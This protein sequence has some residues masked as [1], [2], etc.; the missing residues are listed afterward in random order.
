MVPG[1]RVSGRKVVVVGAGVAGL[2]AASVLAKDGADVTVLERRPYVGG[3]AYSYAHP[4]L[5]E[6]VDSQHVLLGCCTNLLAFCE[7]AGLAGKVRWYDR[8]TFLEPGGRASTIALSG[9]PAPLHYA[10]S[11]L[12]ASMLSVADKL[13]IARGLMEFT[14]GYPQVDD[15]SVLQW[16]RRTRQTDGAIRHFWEPIVLATLNDCA[17]NCSMKYAGKVFYELFLKTS[18]GGKLGIPT[19][20][21]SEFYGAGTRLVEANGGKV[22]LRS[23]VESMTQQA[24]GRW[25]LTSGETSFVADDV[26]LALPFEQTQRLVGGMALQGADDDERA[27]LLGKIERFVH[28]PF[29]SILLWYDREI[30]DLDHAWLLDTTI[31]WFFHKSRI[32]GYAKDRGSYVELVIAGSK[33]ELPMTRAEILEPA[34]AELVRFFPEAGRA[35][36]VKSGILKEARAT[37]SV[38]TGLDQYRPSQR[39]G[40]PGLFLA[41][42]WTATDWPS[43]MEGA[44]RSG[45]L[46][47]G[48]VAGDRTKYLVPELRAEGLM[49]LF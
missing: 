35:K 9:L 32:R 4:A 42:D 38:T 26:I 1:D 24:D 10:G 36:L 39:T 2:S 44:A 40:I 21:L 16:Y 27:D 34:L 6:V 48:E 7:D 20:P 8:Q 33:T 28:S 47:A 14:H 11:F 49:R 46:A 15:E 31:Q 30:T 45:R 23:S 13:A 12:K 41:G 25:L 37:F 3:R 17:A 19:V 18:V 29:I 5:E 43:T 22:E